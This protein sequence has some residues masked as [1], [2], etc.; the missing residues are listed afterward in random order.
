MRN[1]A[2]AA[3]VTTAL[4]PRPAGEPNPVNRMGRTAAVIR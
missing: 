3:K 1:P 4:M 2:D